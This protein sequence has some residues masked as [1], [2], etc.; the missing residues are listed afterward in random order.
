MADVVIHP[1]RG[2]FPELFT[3]PFLESQHQLHHG[4]AYFRGVKFIVR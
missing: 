3:L 1:L 2:V 4:A